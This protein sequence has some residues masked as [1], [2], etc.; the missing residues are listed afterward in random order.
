LL[1]L[2]G[3]IPTFIHI[4]EGKVHEVNILD[5]LLPEAG[6]I[7]V[8]DRGY[9]DFY[10]LHDLTE[11]A[12]FFVIRAK[13]NL[14]C[15]RLYSGNVDRSS[16]LLCD[17]TIKLTGSTSSKYYPEKLRRIKVRDVETGKVIVLLTNNF[18]L[19]AAT[20]AQLYRCRWQI[21]LFFKWIKQNLRIKA[22]YGTS[23]NAVKTQIWIAVTVYLLVAIMKKRLQI[24]TSLYT[25]LQVLSVSSFERIEINQL[26][27]KSGYKTEPDEINN[28]LNLFRNYS[29]H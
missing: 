17:Q 5:E 20:I 4:S 26:L 29:G 19:P 27:A 22:F 9:L 14:A 3:N 21:E 24:E 2:R 7:Y 16:G 11:A 12:A 15:K 8:M 25:I 23:E 1:D 6:A 18:K 28:Q 13:S 10:R